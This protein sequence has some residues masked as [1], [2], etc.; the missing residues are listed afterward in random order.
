M[1]RTKRL[2]L[3]SISTAIIYGIVWKV[4]FGKVYG[5]LLT[6]KFEF[7]ILGFM[8]FLTVDFIKLT[9]W[10]LLFKEVDFIEACKIYIV[11]QAVNETAPIG[12]GE[13]TRA[14][15]AKERHRIFF[16]D[17]LASAAVERIADTSF[18]ISLSVLGSFFIVTGSWFGYQIL[19]P[20]AIVSFFYLLLIKPDLLDNFTLKLDVEKR[21]EK[22]IFGI[23][24]ESIRGF[25]TSF[26]TAL[27]NFHNRKLILVTVVLFTILAWGS[28][29]VGHKMILLSM[30]YDIPTL[31]VLSIAAV[32][33]II[34]I[35][36]FLP[37]GLGTRD[38]AYS[39]LLNMQ[40]VPIEISM[41]SALIYRA[42]TYLMLGVG[43]VFVLL[44]WR[45]SSENK[46]GT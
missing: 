5:S 1:N 3:L 19:I 20:L 25:I 36:S 11:G 46:N 8:I 27:S 23:C 29:A 7:I 37:G 32:S 40:G 34:G 35:F 30:G 38:A 26:K 4:G 9:R 16:G 6:A 45:G 44:S 42:V 41:S 24:A 22:N 18:L 15:I 21:T 10:A 31:T 12:S 17:T 28:E 13:L 43:S 14:Y 33:W 2:L 39:I